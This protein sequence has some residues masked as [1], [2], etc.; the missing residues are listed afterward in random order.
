MQF[1]PLLSPGKC[2]WDDCRP[3]LGWRVRAHCAY[4]M[5]LPD[6]THRKS[7]R[8]KIAAPL[9]LSVRRIVEPLAHFLASFEER[10]VLLIDSDGDAILRIAPH[11]RRPLFHEEHTEAA[12]LDAVAPKR[13]IGCKVI[14][15]A[16]LGSKQRSRRFGGVH[17]CCPATQ[18][19]CACDCSVRHSL[20]V[21]FR[22]SRSV[23]NRPR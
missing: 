15:A 16:R 19:A 4:G 9:Q 1:G 12:H 2:K 22:W 23:G 18:Q 3:P 8:R 13:R 6:T 14:S 11:P 7:C 20:G 21:R 17:V 10:H 5:A